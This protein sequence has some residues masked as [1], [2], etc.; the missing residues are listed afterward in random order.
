MVARGQ[1]ERRS[2]KLAESG[3]G[4][5]SGPGGGLLKLRWK[6]LGGGPGKEPGWRRIPEWERARAGYGGP[7]GGRTREGFPS[8]TRASCGL[9]PCS[10]P[11]FPISSAAPVSRP[12]TV[13][14]ASVASAGCHLPLRDRRPQSSALGLYYLDTGCCGLGPCISPILSF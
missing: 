7:R 10:H 3:S 1:V 14:A 2:V 5:C 12:S 9:S 11:A 8:L 13:S 6:G 4:C